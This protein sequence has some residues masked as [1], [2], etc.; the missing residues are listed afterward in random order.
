VVVDD[1]PR[2]SHL[3]RLGSDASENSLAYAEEFPVPSWPPEPARAPFEE[4]E[5]VRLLLGA[6]LKRYGRIR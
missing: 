6:C 5:E 4:R 3:V 2:R 1:G